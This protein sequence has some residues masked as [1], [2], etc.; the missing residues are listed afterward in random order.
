MVAG[1]SAGETFTPGKSELWSPVRISRTGPQWNFDVSPDG[2]RM[3]V[4][5]AL[6]AER[7][8]GAI[9]VLVLLNFFD[10]LRRKLP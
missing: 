1:Y 3:V 7:E 5:P 9:P 4:F 6:E 8:K 2:K 10:E